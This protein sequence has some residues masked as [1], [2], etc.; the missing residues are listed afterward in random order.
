MTVPAQTQYPS[1]LFQPR[2]EARA[3][4]FRSPPNSAT[5]GRVVAGVIEASPLYLWDHAEATSGNGG[6]SEGG[7][8]CSLGFVV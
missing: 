5:I 4:D 6:A 1:L 8:R 3:P 7:L 2:G